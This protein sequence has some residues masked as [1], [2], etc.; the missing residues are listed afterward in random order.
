MIA[1]KAQ[2]PY[3]SPGKVQVVVQVGPATWSGYYFTLNN[4]LTK[5]GQRR[6]RRPN[7]N[8]S[9]LSSGPNS[10]GLLCFLLS[11]MIHFLSR[12]YV[13]VNRNLFCRMEAMLTFASDEG[14]SISR[15]NCLHV[16]TFP[17]RLS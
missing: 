12:D 7:L 11:K 10:T 4:D 15:S 17:L 6:K 13:T 16:L 2:K 5:L 9:A 3:R 8:S 14:F 1:T